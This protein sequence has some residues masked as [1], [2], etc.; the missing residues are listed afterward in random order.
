MKRLTWAKAVAVAVSM[1]IAQ[2]AS[3]LTLESGMLT[4]DADDDMG[5]NGIGEWAD[6]ATY[7]SWDIDDLGGGVWSY[8]YTWHTPSKE[9]SHFIIEVTD[10]ALG[11]DFWD[12]SMVDEQGNAL[13]PTIYDPIT[14]G[15]GAS[16]PGMDD[17]IY[18]IKLEDFGDV[19]HITTCFLSTHSPTWGDFY[20]KDGKSQLVNEQLY[21]LNA[22]F[23]SAPSG[24]GDD[25][26]A[27]VA[28]PNGD[29]THRVPD[30]ASTLLLTGFALLS[31]LSARKVRAR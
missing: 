12:F 18:G 20:A 2:G 8:C 10:G 30:A 26:G 19:T 13:S 16:N 15:P 21:A 6:P 5:L 24:A 17:P 31:L 27:F 14:Y 3:A 25:G 29:D 4:W 7:I 22:G 1:F 9:I 23:S 11:D 28:V